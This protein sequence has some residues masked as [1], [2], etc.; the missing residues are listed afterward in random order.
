MQRLIAFTIGVLAAGG[1]VGDF[2]TKTGLKKSNP[3]V[4]AGGATGSAAGEQ[5]FVSNVQPLLLSTL[6]GGNGSCV[7][8]HEGAAPIGPALFGLTNADHYRTLTGNARMM[9]VSPD[10]ALFRNHAH[11]GSGSEF[12]VGPDD[13]YDDCINNELQIVDAWLAIEYQ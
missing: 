6:R 8:C 11:V 7:S 2:E 3:G 4:D 1:C 12:C 9:G 5:Y 10:T 13:P